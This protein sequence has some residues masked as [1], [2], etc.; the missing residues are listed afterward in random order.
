MP[1]YTFGEILTGGTNYLLQTAQGVVDIK[2]QLA[3]I[4]SARDRV[5]PLADGGYYYQDAQGQPAYWEQIWPPE[6]P[7]LQKFLPLALGGLALVL[8]LTARG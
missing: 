5:Q 7:D 3:E 8:L 4:E 2:A 6:G 1:G